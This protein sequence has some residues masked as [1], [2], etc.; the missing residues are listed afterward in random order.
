MVNRVTISIIG[1]A[2]IGTAQTPLLRNYV[3]DKMAAAYVANPSGSK[4]WL[5]GQ[6]KG[7]G[8]PSATLGLGLG[9]AAAAYSVYGMKK[10]QRPEYVYGALSYGVPAIVGGALSGLFPTTQWQAAV[11]ADPPAAG[12]G[13][14]AVGGVTVKRVSSSGVLSPFHT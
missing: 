14:A 3:D 10:G 13:A 1:G 12:S 11:A 8:S 6:L 4:P 2:A 5:L 9:G 7:F